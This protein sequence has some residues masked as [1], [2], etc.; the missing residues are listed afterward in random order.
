M[1]LG[2]YIG[3]L[4][5]LNEISDLLSSLPWAP[6]LLQAILISAAVLIP[7]RAFSFCAALLAPPGAKQKLL[8]LWPLLLAADLLWCL[9]PLLL[10]H[11]IPFGLAL[12]FAALLVYAPF[13]QRSLI[14][15]GAAAGPGR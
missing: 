2:F 15:M 11:H 6:Q 14:L 10:L 4:A 12:S 8:R 1:Y 9:A 3:A 7:V 13:A 5:K